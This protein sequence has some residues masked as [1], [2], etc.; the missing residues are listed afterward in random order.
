MHNLTKKELRKQI[1][2]LRNAL[3]EETRIEKS[4]IITNH[5]INHPKF[6]SA[7]SILLF[8]S[9][10]SEVDTTA[11]MEH[12][13]AIGKPL[14]FPKI[15]SMG[16]AGNKE[17]EFYRIFSPEDLYEGYK[18]IREPRS[19]EELHFEPV[20][21]ENI[22]ILM[23]GAVFDL[24]GNRIG[25]GGGFYD[26]FLE[27]LKDL[28]N[29]VEDASQAMHISSM[30]LAFECQLVENGGFK[31]E[32]HDIKVDYIITEKREVVAG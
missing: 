29:G 14:Y 23:P 26:R 28:G 13:L 6:Q 11:I 31:A 24:E 17:M 9:Y 8:A 15:E 12:A 19:Q 21:G 10:K 16:Q 1:L 30:A 32:A 4:K 18:G 3:S 2:Q 20:E 22:L 27:R 5:I 25:Y 7:D